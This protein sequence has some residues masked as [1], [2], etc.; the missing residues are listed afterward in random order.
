MASFNSGGIFEPLF[1]AFDQ[2]YCKDA[3]E[4]AAPSPSL[5][6]TNDVHVVPGYSGDSSCGG[7]MKTNVISVSYAGGESG[8]TSSTL[9]TCNEMGKVRTDGDRYSPCI[10]TNDFTV[11]CA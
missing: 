8:P 4:S 7:T 6:H 1:A 5:A 9:R 3:G 11:A 10:L 2:Q